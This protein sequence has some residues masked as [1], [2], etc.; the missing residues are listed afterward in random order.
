MWNRAYDQLANDEG[1]KELVEAYLK[2]VKKASRPA[3]D[4]KGPDADE[5]ISEIKDQAGRDRL[6]QGAIK[7]GQER[8]HKS[9]KATSAVGKVSGFV[10][11]FKDVVDF[12][13]GTNPQAA[14]PWAGVC[15]GLTVSF[16]G[17]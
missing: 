5:D 13:V 14:L 16:Y 9:T 4:G 3:G 2:A 12:A 15:I 6:L 7:S 8:I 11:K 17:S 10:L 1:T